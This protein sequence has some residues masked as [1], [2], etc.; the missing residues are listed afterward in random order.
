DKVP[1]L[2]AVAMKNV[3]IGPSPLWLQCALVAMGSKAINNIVD[4]TN[5]VMLL[6][7]QPTHAYDY[8]KIRGAKLGA[9]MAQAG[10]KVELLNGKAYELTE[11][12]IVIAD[13]E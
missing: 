5:Y 13:N 1:R 10:E 12:D 7:A 11:D 2:M 8:D 6:T 9:R 4:V 3:E